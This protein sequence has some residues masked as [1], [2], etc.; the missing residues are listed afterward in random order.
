MREGIP[1]I[2]VR[3]LESRDL[4]RLVSLMEELAESAR[5]GASFSVER[6]EPIFRAMQERPDT[7]LNLVATAGGEVAGFVSVVFYRSFFHRV[8]TALINELVVAQSRRGEGI[9]ARLIAA[10]K[11]EAQRREMDE[12]EVGT[13]TANRAARDFYHKQGFDEEYL[14]LEMELDPS[15]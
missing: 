5:A 4:E 8:G 13:E 11:A 3:A 14:L 9:G 10:V 15:G 12:V 6:F 2:A 7:Y 1:E